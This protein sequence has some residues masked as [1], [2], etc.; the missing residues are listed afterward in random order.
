[1]GDAGAQTD[2]HR[3]G[4]ISAFRFDAR[5]GGRPADWAELDADPLG[6]NVHGDLWVHLDR[7]AS[8]VQRWLTD[9]AR[10]PEHAAEVLLAEDPRP[11]FVHFP[12]GE[13]H[14]EGFVLIL[15]A[16][17]LNPDADPE[18]MVA[19]RLWV[20]ANRVISLRGR[21]LMA[22]DALDRAFREGRGPLNAPDLIAHLAGAMLDRIDTVV[23]EL[24]AALEEAEE[25]V[26]ASG[27]EISA[28]RRSAVRLRRYLGPQRDVLLRA[29]SDWPAWVGK[30]ERNRLRSRA[31]RVARVV[32]DIEELIARSGFAQEERHARLAERMNRS[33]VALTI[34]ATVFLPMSLVASIWGMNTEQLPFAEH[35]NGFWI[36]NALIVLTGVGLAVFAWRMSRIG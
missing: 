9:T 32:E 27:E 31:E 7:T 15:R 33:N 2:T 1:M 20:D 14:P 11:K 23:D 34:V 35:P 21:K 24:E 6:S 13:S 5:G 4:L 22:E 18:N 17:N 12:A 10:L 26:E 30:R 19:I 28:V 8:G 25:R 16:V 29:G 3:P 36:V